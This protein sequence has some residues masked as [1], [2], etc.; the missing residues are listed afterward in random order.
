MP[1]THRTP[2]LPAPRPMIIDLAAGL[3]PAFAMVIISM[4]VISQVLA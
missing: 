2:A 3:A 1:H 4:V